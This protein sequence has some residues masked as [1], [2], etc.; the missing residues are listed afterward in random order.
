M[1][2]R[3]A[4]RTLVLPSGA[5]K[6]LL[7]CEGCK[8]TGTRRLERHAPAGWFYMVVT[9]EVPPDAKPELCYVYACSQA[10]AMKLWQPGPGQLQSP[11]IYNPR[12]ATSG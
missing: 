8:A 11:V 5:M 12:R 10:C 7:T 1:T 2:P 3:R 6:E 9:V 4:R